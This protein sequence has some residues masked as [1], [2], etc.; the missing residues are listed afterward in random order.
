MYLLWLQIIRIG[1]DQ[2]VV[3]IL[4]KLFT[5]CLINRA[6]IKNGHVR[7]TISQFEFFMLVLSAAVIVIE[8][9]V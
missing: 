7:V 8:T 2:T 1:T 9:L 5:A 4:S 3:A 6:L